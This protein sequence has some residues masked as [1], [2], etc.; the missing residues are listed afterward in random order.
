MR[1]G[2]EKKKEEL[3]RADR[4][5][6]HCGS[7]TCLSPEMVSDQQTKTCWSEE[8]NG[9]GI[10]LILCCAVSTQQGPELLSGAER[11]YAAYWVACGG[12][13]TSGRRRLG[14]LWL[15]NTTNFIIQ[16]M[17]QHLKNLG[18]PSPFFCQYILPTYS[19]SSSFILCGVLG[20]N[21]NLISFTCV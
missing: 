7:V 6:G 16:S 21:F 13:P 8:V 3:Q 5:T 20:V 14:E 2:K 17:T 11:W 18:W 12:I 19:R 4:V 9:P 15:K 1:S 10:L